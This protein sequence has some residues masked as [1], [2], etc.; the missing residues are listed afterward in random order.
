VI[1]ISQFYFPLILS[2][3]NLAVSKPDLIAPDVPLP[4]VLDPAK[5]RFFIGVSF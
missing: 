5:Y 2:K 1:I 4:L 3:I